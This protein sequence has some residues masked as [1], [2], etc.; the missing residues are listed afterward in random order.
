MGYQLCLVH[1]YFSEWNIRTLR[2]LFIIKYKFSE[3]LMFS[4]QVH[5]CDSTEALR[6][7]AR[8]LIYNTGR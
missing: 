5:V 2:V 8:L 3:V 7:G 4:D 1:I 6:F